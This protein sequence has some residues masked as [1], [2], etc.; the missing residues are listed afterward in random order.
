M[1]NIMQRNLIKLISILTIRIPIYVLGYI[2]ALLLISCSDR[3][4]DHAVPTTPAIEIIANSDWPV[5]GLDHGEQRFSPL[6][7][8]NRDNVAKLGLAWF[9]DLPG[10]RGQEATPLVVDGVMYT[11]SAWSHVFALDAATGEELWHFDPQVAK[12][13]AAKGCC[14]A[15]NRGAAYSENKVF[16]GTLDG[17]LIALN[18]ESG[19]LIWSTTTVDQ[20]KQ[21]TITGAPRVIDSK[22]F[23]GNGGAEFGVRGYISAYDAR[24]G[25]LLW[26]FYTVPGGPN[27]PTGVEPHELSSKTWY[28]SWWKLGGGGT[29][30]D[31]MAYDKDTNTL[32][33]GV[34]N[35]S[36]WNPNIRSAGKGD[37][38]FLSSIVAV[39]ATSGEYR[40]HYQTTP[41][42][43]WDYTATQH[44][45]LADLEIDGQIRNVLLQAP[46]NGFFYVLDR[47]TGELISA[48]P[49][50][51][52]TWASKI[53]IETGRPVVNPQAEYW[54]TGQVA[55]VAP[56]WT[57]GHN[58]HPMSYST[59]T[60][61]V[62]LPA[63]ETAFPYLGD[64]KQT[65]SSIATNLGVDVSAASFP[66]NQ[67]MI[68]LA[69]Q[70]TTGM[71]LAWDPIQQKE[72]WRAQHR[73]AW[74]GGVLATAGGLVFQG[75]AAGFFNAY[76][77]DTGAELWQ[78]S[79]QTGIVA[80]P[81]SFA[82]NGDQY[83]SVSAGWGGIFAL[84]SGPIG[85]N[86][87]G[88]DP[89]NRS[90][91]L[92]FKLGAQRTLPAITEKQRTMPDLTS[93]EI[94][95][96]S[97]QAGFRIYDRYCG[98]C[99]GAGAIGGGVVADLRYSSA[100]YSDTAWQ[101]IVIDGALQANGM[102]S[103]AAE[104]SGDDAE[105]IR[106]YVIGRNHYANKIGATKRLSH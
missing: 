58:W 102:I 67:I 3:E 89:V 4:V 69:Q 94:D 54:K 34:G 50:V 97:V 35:G 26:R 30:W 93:I 6:R 5:H 31:S 73:G 33:F 92:T 57:G 48:E 8:I 27:D 47:H 55:A 96:A 78:V 52:V 65:Y 44:M 104:L 70:S 82:V 15:V 81:I 7:A 9:F 41:G 68:A 103:F 72:V 45:V 87:A 83:I 91:I 25:E 76:D 88:G 98:A 46:K 51:R 20:T 71:L 19:K 80:A 106:H 2:C 18:A 63:Q 56:A 13:T 75:S 49:Y 28:G 95:A 59:S 85:L 12:A 36:P 24:T 60:G 61:L 86:A 38:L 99:H 66:D 29:V 11:T 42:E 10:G 79:A 105:S 17:Q 14:D 43:G 77:A 62:Y 32:Y 39:D 37:N 21:Y 100:L 53:D 90:R 16:V 101:K 84:V 22:V 1:L 23:I 64:D 74:N 40:W